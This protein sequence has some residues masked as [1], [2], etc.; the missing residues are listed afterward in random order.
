MFGFILGLWVIQPLVPDYQGNVSQGL[1][2]LVVSQ[3]LATPISFIPQLP[4]KILQIGQIVG[5]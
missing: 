1:C 3:C 2:L 5:H 4:Q